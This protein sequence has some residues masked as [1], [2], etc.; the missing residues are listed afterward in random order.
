WLCEALLGDG[1]EVWGVALGMPTHGRL[2]ATG[3]RDAVHWHL[4]DVRDPAVL[5][6]AV[7]ASRPDA[8]F[9]L[10]GVSY[11]P[12]AEA[13]PGPAYEVNVVAAARL[14]ALLGE[15]RGAGVLDPAVVV[16][17]SG[18]QYG[19]HDGAAPLREE[20]E[21]RPLT[22]YAAT[23]A[24]QE[25]AAFQACRRHGLRVVAARSFNHVGPG[26]DERF[27]LP[28]LVRRTLALRAAGA[29]ELVVG[30][31]T[32]VRDFTH[33]ADVVRAY[34]Q[35]AAAGAPGTAYN[36]SSGEGWSVANV[37]ELVAQRVGHAVRLR[38]DPALVRPVDLPVLVGDPTRLVTHTGW[39]RRRTLQD[40]IDDLIHAATH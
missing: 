28:S 26:Q 24:A 2:V 36:V 18:E 17:G 4:G 11:V 12:Q 9:H 1:W 35:L 15:R 7:E 29:R 37:A 34:I 13:D 33:V 27:L 30:N 32:P 38:E 40:S 20:A 22:V 25:V 6:G 8:V 39:T 14:L 10:A 3:T 16:V 21:Q 23:K 31:T 5:T 19:R